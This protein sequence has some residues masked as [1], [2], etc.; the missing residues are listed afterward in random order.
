[1]S[2]GVRSYLKEHTLDFPGVEVRDQYLRSYPQG[3]MAAQLLG[4]LGEISAEQLKDAALQ[5]LRRPATWSARTASSTPTTSGCAAATGSPASRSTPSAGPSRPSPVGG[6]MPEP[7]DTLVTTLDAKVQAAAEEALRTGISLA[8]SDG[9]Y[10]AN[11]GAAVVLDVKNGEILG[12]ASYP[13]YDPERVG[14][15]HQHQGL[16]AAD[17]E[18]RQQPA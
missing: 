13:T 11:G 16:Q 5:G 17:Q 7:G 3:D 4:H 6:R 14:R 15:R 8:H 10:A 2:K 12:M 1:M 9:K 18:E